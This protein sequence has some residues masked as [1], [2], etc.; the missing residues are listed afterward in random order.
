MNYF[1]GLDVSLEKTHICVLD[2]N[3]AVVLETSAASTPEAISSALEGAP[4]CKRVVFE[5][6]RMAPMLYHGLADLDVPVICI[7]SRQ[8]YQA[9]KTLAT[10][11]TDRNDARG[12]AQLARTGFFKPVH[13]KSLPSHAVRA[14]I[15]ARKKLVGQRITLENQIRGLAVVFGVRLPR[16]LSPAFVEEV[17]AMSDGI[18]GLSSAMRGLVAARDAVLAAVAAIDADMKRLVRASDACRRL[19]TIPGVGPLTALAFTAAI[20]DPNRFRR[21]RDLGAYLGLVPRRYQS[22]EIDYS[23]SIS[24]VGDRRVRT[25]LYEAANVMLTRFKGQLKL[26]DWAIAIARRSNMRKARIALARR[27]AI[28]MHAMLKHGTEFKPA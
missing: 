12:L 10:H 28:I 18:A 19:M 22:G 3:G 2:R 9:L 16:G 17:I 21:S 24:K 1:A 23:G 6:G 4:A 26:K 25:L 27:L 8:A 13:V 14:L 7:E 20:D 11:K 15:M 5:T